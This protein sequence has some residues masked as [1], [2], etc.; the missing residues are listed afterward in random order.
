MNCREYWRESRQLLE[1]V[2]GG[3]GGTAMDCRQLLEGVLSEETP[4]NPE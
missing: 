1:G 2:R 4:V 3:V